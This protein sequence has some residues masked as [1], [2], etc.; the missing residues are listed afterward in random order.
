MI[1]HLKNKTAIV[2]GATKGLGETTA[3]MLVQNGAN[4]VICSRS[5]EDLFET[6]KNLEGL[7]EHGNTVLAL[8]CD[9]SKPADVHRLVVN[10]L[11]QFGTCE[12]LVNNAGVYGPK[13]CFEELELEDWKRAFDINFY[14]SVLVT[15]SLIPHFKSQRY[16]KIVQLSG[17]GA[18]G[19]LPMLSAYA[20]SKAAIVRFMETLSR[21][22][23]PYNVDINAVA[24]GALNTRLLD[25]VIDA[26]PAVVGEK[27]YKKS[28]EQASN[29]GNSI[30]LAAELIC[31]LSSDKSNGITGK[32]ISAVWDNWRDFEG[33]SEELNFSDVMTLRRLNGALSGVDWVD[34]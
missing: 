2:T 29:G 5:E 1:S 33:R 23:S 20:A 21:E 27:F 31:F 8:R 17:G 34:V 6:K 14:G 28:L 15:R 4:V 9:V 22:V 16:G 25:E 19:P 3:K 30:E 12:V 18:T 32:L 7:S 13:G 10:S 26:G 24:P 11:A